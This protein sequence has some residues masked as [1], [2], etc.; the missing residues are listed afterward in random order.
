MTTQVKERPVSF[1][2]E[3]VRAILSGNKTVTRR[4]VKDEFHGCLTGDCPHEM[5]IDCDIALHE[6][7]PYGIPG[8]RL[9]VREK[10]NTLPAEAEIIYMADGKA[11]RF[12]CNEEGDFLEGIKRRK[13][14]PQPTCPDGQAESIWRLSASGLNGCRILLRM[15]RLRKGAL[16][17][18]TWGK[19]YLW[20]M[21]MRCKV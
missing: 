13:Y 18:W 3:M 15:M 4:I 11:S 10:F 17:Q 5:Q 21:D 19:R 9:W 1:N 16:N 2:G 20:A 7:C 12:L 14:S 6:I 8:D